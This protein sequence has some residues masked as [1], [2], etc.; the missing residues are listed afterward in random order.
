MVS[1]CLLSLTSFT[2]RLR[3]EKPSY[4]TYREKKK[5]DDLSNMWGSA[6]GPI[7]LSTYLISRDIGTAAQESPSAGYE[8]TQCCLKKGQDGLLSRCR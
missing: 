1:H 7:N 3:S 2:V 5:R 8:R 6:A 4:Y